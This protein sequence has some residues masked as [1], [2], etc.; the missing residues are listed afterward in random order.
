M[1]DVLNLKIND[2]SNVE[3]EFYWRENV[4]IGKIASSAEQQMGEQF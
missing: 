2:R 4:R 3:L 1:A